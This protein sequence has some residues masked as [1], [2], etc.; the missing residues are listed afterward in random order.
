MSQ[1]RA[2][3]HVLAFFWEFFCYFEKFEKPRVRKLSDRFICQN[4]ALKKARND[5]KDTFWIFS[6][7]LYVWVF[8]IFVWINRTMDTENCCLLNC[9]NV[10]YL[11][12]VGCKEDK[13]DPKPT[14]FRFF[15][16]IMI[17]GSLNYCAVMS[18]YLVFFLCNIVCILIDISFY[19][20]KFIKSW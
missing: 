11:P 2:H 5:I 12:R 17:S 6:W 4:S 7:N 3:K 13:L 19:K 10:L 14:L 18:I 9:T 16:C 20:Y 8:S 1:K 15:P